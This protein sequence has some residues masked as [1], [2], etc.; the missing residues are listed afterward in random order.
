MFRRLQKVFAGW[1]L[2]G[3]TDRRFQSWCLQRCR[4]L[5]SCAYLNRLQH[6]KRSLQVSFGTSEAPASIDILTAVLYHGVDLKTYRMEGVS[7]RN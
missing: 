7:E 4:L 6:L 2:V 3:F 1:L 5:I